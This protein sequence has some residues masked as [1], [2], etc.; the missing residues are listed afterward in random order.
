MWWSPDPRFVILPETLHI[1]SSMNKVLER[2]TFEFRYNTAF[3]EV[4]EECSKIKRAGQRGTWITNEMKQAYIDLHEAGY[5]YSGESW[6][7][8]KLAGGFYGVRLGKCF[9]GESMFS[10]E[11]NASKA[12]FLTF[13]RAFFKMGGV[14]IDCQVYTEHLESLGAKM[15]PRNRFVELIRG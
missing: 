3:K 13:A 2:D 1:S 6:K 15:I 5:A 12:A 14:M 7:D 10:K 8:G 9:F 4:I 11:T